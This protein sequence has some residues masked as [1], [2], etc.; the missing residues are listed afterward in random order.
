M[1]ACVF[2]YVPVRRHLRSC[3]LNVCFCSVETWA[4]GNPGVCNVS[5][6][7]WDNRAGLCLFRPSRTSEKCSVRLQGAPPPTAW[8]IRWKRGGRVTSPSTC[9][10]TSV[11]CRGQN[12]LQDSLR[13][14]LSISLQHL[15]EQRYVLPPR[16]Q[17]GL[18]R[19]IVLTHGMMIGKTYPLF[20]FQLTKKK[21]AAFTAGVSGNLSE[22][23]PGSKTVE[24]IFG[25]FFFLTNSSG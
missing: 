5:L 12:H 17:L 2:S 19:W 15:S 24:C 22:I 18:Q 21:L 1:W 14:K 4:E 16:Q 13:Q 3:W 25:W 11:I 8:R 20:L 7:H 9:V 10:C 6:S 23:T